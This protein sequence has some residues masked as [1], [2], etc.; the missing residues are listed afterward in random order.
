VTNAPS[1]AALESA[2]LAALV[3][4]DVVVT[5]SSGSFEG[6]PRRLLEA[7]GSSR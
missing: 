1:Q 7:L 5:M 4:G 2:L 3:G 6:L